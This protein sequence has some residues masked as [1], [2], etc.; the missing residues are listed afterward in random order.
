MFDISFNFLHFNFCYPGITTENTS[1][2][3]CY[4]VIWIT[5]ICVRWTKI[6]QR[7]PLPELCQFCVF[8]ALK[9]GFLARYFFSVCTLLL[10]LYIYMSIVILRLHCT[11]PHTYIKHTNINAKRMEKRINFVSPHGTCFRFFRRIFCATLIFPFD[12]NMLARELVDMRWY[13]CEY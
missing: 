2:K 10:I 7:N 12:Q 9:K 6:E 13:A 3:H 5:R 11:Q 4:F 1:V 8:F